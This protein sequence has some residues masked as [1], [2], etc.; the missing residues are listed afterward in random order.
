[1][2]ASHLGRGAARKRIDSRVQVLAALG[3]TVG[4]IAETNAPGIPGSARLEEI[5]CHAHAHG[6]GGGRS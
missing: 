3:G 6:Q 2:V 4:E 5:G 1:V